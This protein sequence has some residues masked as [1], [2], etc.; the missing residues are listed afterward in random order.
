V[1]GET[2]QQRHLKRAV[3]PLEATLSGVGIILGAGIYALIGSVAEK[4][5][6]GVWLSFLISG[7]MAVVIGLCYAELAS[8]FPR[9]GADYE[10][11]RR[12]LGAR[13]AFVVGWL[14]VIANLVGAA[15]VALGF[16]SYFVNF[17]SVGL[18]EVAAALLVVATLIAFAGIQHAVWVSVILTVVEAGGLV[19]VIA[20][21]VPHLDDVSLSAT[22]AGFAGVASGAA[23]VMFAFIGFEQIATLA[24]ETERPER[25][26]PVA[27]LTAIGVT[28]TLYLLVAV[29][30]V[31]VV[32]WERLAAAES[33]LSEVMEEAVGGR[34]S[35]AIALVA[36]FS[37]A[38]TVLLM[39]VAGSRLIY[40]M[41]STAGLPRFLAW[42]H[43][44]VHTPARAIVLA[45]GVSLGFVLLEDISLVASATNFAVF[46]GFAAVCLS[47]VVL[48]RRSPELPRPFRAPL[49]PFGVP[50]MPVAG[51]LLVAF[52]MANLERDAL[53]LGAGLF[54]SGILAME[55]LSLWR[56][57][58]GGDPEGATPPGSPSRSG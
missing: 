35:D 49:N 38:N 56:P 20:A 54:A 13:A 14:I 4:A 55:V 11:T 48:R 32:G 34:A 27:M 2:R 57:E 7:A 3:G 28:T 45:L 23:L 51:I 16:A 10:Y 26:I 50:L 31:A 25:V 30:A 8:M 53:L 9:A 6:D 39:L 46:I 52:L 42:V 24:E 18:V 5:R 40:G 43:P 12:A 29:S 36:L 41:A 19:F 15:T 58:G 37:T 44:G 1:E 33:P 47:L 17:W 21:G 22:E